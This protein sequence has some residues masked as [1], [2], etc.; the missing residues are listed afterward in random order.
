[1][2][3]YWVISPYDSTNEAVFDKA[4]D[5]DLRHGT[6]AIG[7]SHLGDTSALSELE[8]EAQHR[9]KYGDIPA[10]F[11]RFRRFRYEI[12]PGDIIIARQGRKK[13]LNYGTVSGQPFYNAERGKERIDA[14]VNSTADP[15]SNF[16]PVKWEGVEKQF[17]RI[18]LGMTTLYRISEA[19]FNELMGEEPPQ[20]EEQAT[21][22][23]TEFVLEKY[24]EN[25]IVSN[26]DRIFEGQLRYGDLEGNAG[27]QYAT[28][29][30]N[31]DILATK[32]GTKSYMVM[33]LK[34]G[35]GSDRVV[36]QILRYMGWVKKHLC[37]PGE[38]V[39]GLVICR[40]R[41]ERLEY[42]LSVVDSVS[43]K[44]YQVDFKLVD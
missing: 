5:Y 44:F 27:Q 36:G 38:N 28:D 8:L 7:W 11:N 30:G 9:E 25:F 19:R 22:Q 6:I 15:Y 10:G 12:S 3:R 35:R 32:L 17:D 1:M 39:E 29:I 16:M 21:A 26:F 24:L 41:D 31:I 4:W 18:V 33:E 13:I 23:N 43:A 37:P 34:K 2:P 20:D 42:A 40:D 14:S